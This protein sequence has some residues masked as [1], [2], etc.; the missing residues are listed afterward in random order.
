MLSGTAEHVLCI[1]SSVVDKNLA[2]ILLTIHSL[3]LH[4]VSNF[5]L[6]YLP[7]TATGWLKLG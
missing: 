2:N 3:K 4:L 5:I 6:N 1:S 7:F